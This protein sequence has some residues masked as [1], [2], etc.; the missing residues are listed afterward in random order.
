MAPLSIGKLLPHFSTKSGLLTRLLGTSALIALTTLTGEVVCADNI[1]W[2]VDSATAGKQAGDGIWDDTTT[3]NWQDDNVTTVN[4]TQNNLGTRQDRVTFAGANQT[5]TLGSDVYADYIRL[6]STGNTIADDG[7]GAFS[8]GNDRRVLVQNTGTNTISANISQLLYVR[9]NGTLNFSG[10]S[11]AITQDRDVTLNF[12]GTTTGDVRISAGSLVS[13]GEIG[14]DL[15]NT[16]TSTISGTLNRHIVNSNA[17]SVLINGDLTGVV[18]IRNSD[19]ATLQV[20]AG[21]TTSTGAL[22][23]TSTDNVS[24]SDGATLIVDSANIASGSALSVAGPAGILT[25][26]GGHISNL[27]TLDS[28]GTLNGTISNSG[29]LDVSGSVNGSINNIGSGTPT[30]S[31]DLNVG[32]TSGAITNTSTATNSITLAAGQTLTVNELTNNAAN[33][34]TIDG[35]IVGDVDNQQGSFGVASTGQIDGDVTNSGTFTANGGT[36]VDP[37]VTGDVTNNAGTSNLG[38]FVGGDLTNSGTGVTEITT[39]LSVAGDVTQSSTGALHVFKLGSEHLWHL[40]Q[41]QV[42]LRL[43]GRGTIARLQPPY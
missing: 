1:T 27:G 28:D 3:A 5:I 10:D 16:T 4:R 21:T 32:G 22:T 29:S 34:A 19:T 8:I 42:R 14:R 15:I 35:A 25:A 41:S 2:D 12:S 43:M 23:Q 26:S 40:R 24:I 33:A 31:G 39:S 37:I 11:T 30:I 38:G 6:Q 7:S 20:T 18:D 9:G 13:T 36:A 17:G